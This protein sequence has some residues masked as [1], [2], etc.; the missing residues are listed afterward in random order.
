MRNLLFILLLLF[1]CLVFAQADGDVAP[2]VEEAE[3]AGGIAIGETVLWDIEGAA[4][5]DAFRAGVREAL[6]ADAARHLL[7]EKAFKEYTAAQSPLV[8]RCYM[9]TE[10]CVA[11]GAVV[12]DALDISSVVGVRLSEGRAAWKVVDG[13]GEIVRKGEVLEANPRKLGF[14]VVAEIFD[15]TGIVSVTTTPPGATV[16]LDGRPIGTTPLTHRVGVGEHELTIRMQDFAVIEE[17]VEIA[18]GRAATL[19]RTMK[20]LPGTLTITDAPDGAEV[21][22][23]GELAGRAGEPLS[24]EPGNYTL[25]VRAEGYESMSDAVTV[26]PGIEVSR[27]APLEEKNIFLRDISSE[28]IVF[29]NYILRLGFEYGIH[30]GNFQDARSG[31]DQP[32]EFQGL[33]NDSGTFQSGFQ[34][35]F[36]TTGLRVDAAY[37]LKNFALVV[38]SLSYL[39]SSLKLDGAATLADG[40]TADATVTRVRRLQLRPFQVFYRHFYKNFVPFIEGGI[41]IDFQWLQAEGSAF[42]GPETLRRTDAFW[43]IAVGGQYYFT[44]NLFGMLRY[45]Y[46]DYFESGLGSDHQISL[47]VGAAFPNLFGI[48]T[49]PPEQL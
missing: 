28:A 14:G 40:T 30:Q 16:A 24:L 34:R 39:S 43:T 6:A 2:D 8:P 20:Q 10:D 44:E 33:D 48:D 27:S 31:D 23:N 15:A 36:T 11:P 41:G 38:L 32:V 21:F 7:T 25:E 26:E 35:T 46:Q 12:F 42:T 29:N 47:G 4:G 3:V 45:S 18:S 17:K 5:L 49:E 13:R 1:P 22:V 19:T 37:G 9:G